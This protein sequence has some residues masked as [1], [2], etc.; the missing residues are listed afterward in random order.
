MGMRRRAALIAAAFALLSV[1]G[2]GIVARVGSRGATLTNATVTPN[3]DPNYALTV[4]RV[5]WTL[6]SVPVRPDAIPQAASPVAQLVRPPLD[7]GSDNLI[8]RFSFWRASGTVDAAIAWFETHPPSGMSVGARGGGVFERYL[9]EAGSTVPGE[10]WVV[11]A[12][13]ATG[14]GVAIRVDAMALWTLA[15]PALAR[16]GP[17]DSVDVTVD[18]LNILMD[19]RLRAPTV[20]RTLTGAPAQRLA[21]TIDA[22]LVNPPGQVSCEDETGASDRLIF[23]TRSGRVVDVVESVRAC[24]GVRLTRDGA[25]T[26]LT[27][28][29]DG[30]VMA[31][32]GL[33]ANYGS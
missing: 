12:V 3:P 19:L 14:D 1:V 9:F 26:Q 2:V 25:S 33:P 16:I 17:V 32:L 7:P 4:Q 22:L 10:P 20:H 8:D 24:P 15:K 13:A 6:A 18:R 23:H 5:E 21:D 11:V 31:A 28:S 27:G 29:V 30:Q